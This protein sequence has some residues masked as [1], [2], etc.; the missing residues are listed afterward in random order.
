MA[1]PGKLTNE[2]F[3]ACVQARYLLEV[4]AIQWQERAARA[5]ADTVEQPDVKKEEL[6]EHVDRVYRL[7]R[8]SYAEWRA[9]E[10][11]FGVLNA[12]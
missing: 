5:Y 9:F 8:A 10:Q 7:A 4:E 1:D 3:S 6:Q 11:L 2:Q 12:E